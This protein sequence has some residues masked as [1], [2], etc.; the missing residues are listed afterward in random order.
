[1]DRVL[2]QERVAGR[3]ANRFK[4]TFT[5]T[6]GSIPDGVMF[7]QEG[8]Q[9]ALLKWKGR[10][11]AWAPEEYREGTRMDRGQVV[12][13]LTPRTVVDVIRAGYVSGVHGSLPQP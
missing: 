6:F 8:D 11:W 13:V 5:T 4:P 1:M 3:G 7:H 10:V 12:E 2:H 9:A